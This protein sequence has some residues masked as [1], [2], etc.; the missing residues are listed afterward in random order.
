MHDEYFSN[1]YFSACGEELFFVNYEFDS[2]TV[3]AVNHRTIPR[4][5]STQ[6]KETSHIKHGGSLRL[7]KPVRLK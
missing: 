4:M 1:N 7:R 3:P 5:C 6:V 2:S